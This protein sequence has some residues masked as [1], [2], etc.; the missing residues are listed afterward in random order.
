MALV[1]HVQLVT[2]AQQLQ[3]YQSHVKQENI[4]RTEINK[5]IFLLKFQLVFVSLIDTFLNFPYV[6]KKSNDLKEYS[7]ELIHW[8]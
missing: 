1:K 3:I 6:T 2:N 4:G 5:Y 7:T 8:C